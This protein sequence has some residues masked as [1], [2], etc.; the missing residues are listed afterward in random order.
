[1]KNK[2]DSQRM[3]IKWEY[4]MYV[5]IFVYSCILTYVHQVHPNND[6]G[7]IWASKNERILWT[8]FLCEMPSLT[9]PTTEEKELK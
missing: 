6:Q 2:V 9:L 1:M 3:C 5:Y 7:L 4:D 8:R